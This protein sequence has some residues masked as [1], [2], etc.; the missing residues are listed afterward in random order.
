MERIQTENWLR[1]VLINR[2]WKKSGSNLSVLSTGSHR[3]FLLSFTTKPAFASIIS[4]SVKRINTFKGVANQILFSEQDFR[5]NHRLTTIIIGCQS[6]DFC[7]IS[8]ESF[9]APINISN[10]FFHHALK[11]NTNYENSSSE[12]V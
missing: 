5:D 9:F 11:I 2:G 3:G 4:S 6:A 8:P 7:V 1:S 10:V 12:T